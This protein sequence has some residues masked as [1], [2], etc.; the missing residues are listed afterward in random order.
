MDTISFKIQGMDCAEEVAVLRKELRPLIDDERLSFDLLNARLLLDL[1]HLTQ[2]PTPGEIQQAIRRTGM[3]AI[4]YE[5]YIEREAE[6]EFGL[7]DR[8]RRDILCITAG[9]FTAAGFVIHAG[10]HGLGAALEGEGA[11]GAPWPAVVCY[12]I[13][14]AAGGWTILPRA[15]FAARRIRADINLL[16]TIAAI[17]AV[18]LGNW[19]EAASIVF[20]FTLAQLLESW[21]V[22][23]ARHAIRSLMDLSPP[24]ARYLCPHDG[25]I[26]ER[27][28]AAVPLGATALVRPGERI[29]LDGTVSKGRT[30]VNQAPI[31]GE[32]N[33]V[34]K[35]FGDIVYA[36]TINHEGAFEFTVTHT[37]NDTSLARIIHMVEEAQA[38]RAPSQQWVD[39]FAAYY[40][41]AMILVALAVALIP[42][43]VL[44][45]TW[46][47]SIYQGLVMLLIACP[48][49][50][51]IST[52]VSIVAALASAARA[53]VLIKG[54]VYLESPAG[55]RAVALDKTGTLT[56]GHH[57]VQRLVPLDGHSA[58][59]LLR[60]AASIETSSKHPLA[61]AIVR[62]AQEQRVAVGIA[63]A[64]H[65]LPGRGAEAR[66]NDRTYWIGNQRLAA[67]RGHAE[68]AA[69]D[70]ATALEDAGHSV[71]MLG[72]D[73]HVCGLI[74]LADEVRPETAE[75][76]AALKREGIEHVVMLT[77]D[78][79]GTATSLAEEAG[80]DAFE[81]QLLPQDKLA[82]VERLVRQYG[83]V[84]MIG[85]GV[86]DAPA[87]AAASL[88]IAMGAAGS[89]T[90]IET[91]DIAL[92][93][94][95]LSRLPWLIRH[96]RR[97][98]NIIKQNVVFSLGFKAAVFVLALFGVATLWMAVAADMG[99]SLLVIAN[100]L[101]LLRAE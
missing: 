53:G 90:A 93:S 47:E 100:G 79:L 27:P 39:K 81:A 11:V 65:E 22:G 85:D 69:H 10:L 23:R 59:D 28:V 71:V 94:D 96:S 87:M 43:F 99:A 9:V 18:I 74:S 66:L 38:R 30:S 95:D 55:L 35:E 57:R 7:W 6:R 88:G 60:M 25:D 63:E 5:D 26:L 61:Q 14:L 1:S 48:C 89:D 41:P 70:Q 58:H 82:A 16:M 49:A 84:A 20:L 76:V 80:V 24:T 2:P 37:A 34:P 97:T 75:A 45:W 92:M 72:T 29:P 64:Y 13:A 33:P 67:E 40:T 44:G 42:P 68:S 12:A 101:R 8:R 21:S 83:R 36:G 77:G 91:A 78:N 86:N 62:H 52:P 73:E 98:L 51:V 50:L 15:F 31:T 3:D 46:R 19:F 54:G 32:A 17:G 4:P 56:R